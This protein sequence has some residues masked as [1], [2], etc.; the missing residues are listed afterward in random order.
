[1]CTKHVYSA[2]FTSY[3]VTSLTSE[4]I[5]NAGGLRGNAEIQPNYYSTILSV[6]TLKLVTSNT[7]ASHYCHHLFNSCWLAAVENRWWCNLWPWSCGM[8][9]FGD[10]LNLVPSSTL[11]SRYCHQLFGGCW[12][13][14]VEN[15]WLVK[16]VALIVS[17]GVTMNTEFFNAHFD[18]GLNLVPPSTPASHYIEQLFSM[19]CRRPFDVIEEA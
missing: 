10:T 7:W 14:I 17:S 16:V 2:I 8:H 3:L 4:V 18:D 11:V 9:S 5:Y 12:V 13:Q 1:M 6:E 19:S 15:C